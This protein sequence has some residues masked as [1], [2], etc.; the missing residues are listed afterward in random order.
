MKW[1]Q[2]YSYTS[3][4]HVYQTKVFLKNTLNYL[5]YC[6]VNRCWAVKSLSKNFDNIK[7]T[8]HGCVIMDTKFSTSSNCKNILKYINI[9]NG[10]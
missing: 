6:L 1:Y 3:L 7:N 5:S 10:K 4:Q 8:I 9:L 2:K